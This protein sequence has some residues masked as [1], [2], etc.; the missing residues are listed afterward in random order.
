MAASCDLSGVGKRIGGGGGDAWGAAARG[1]LC[2]GPP[3]SAR[4]DAA[5]PWRGGEDAGFT[6]LE[7]II[8]LGLFALIAVAGLGLLDSVLN[9]Q[10]RTE[11][12]LGRL[13]DLQRAM[14]VIQSD[15]DQVTR[16]EIA[17]GG[18][19]IAFTRVAG[20]VGGPPM[21]VRYVGAGGV[22]V[23]T[24]PGPQALLQGVSATRWRFRDGDAWV[25]RWPPSAERKDEW[26]RAVSVELQVSG[27]GPA[28]VLR[29]VVV[30]PVRARETP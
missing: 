27:P 22:L 30:L 19:A 6:L 21:P 18:S 28:G 17:G 4:C 11:A 23:R 16:G 20:G 8:S 9:V 7:L 15:L 3:P 2:G 29:R 24:A 14:F 10:G 26:P 1:D 5:V 12:R 25:D 13:A